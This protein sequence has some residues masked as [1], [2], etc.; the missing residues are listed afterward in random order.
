[1]MDRLKMQYLDKQFLTEKIGF[2]DVRAHDLISSDNYNESKLLERYNSYNETDRIL[3]YKA[4][5]QLSIIG[6]GQKN[7]GAIRID[8][9]NVINLVDI[10]KKL[11]IKFN[12]NI[13]AKY[14]E[15]EFSVRRLFRFFRYQIQKFIVDNNRPS[16]LWL[17][18]SDK[19]IKFVHIC[20]PGAEHF[21]EKEE[22]LYLLN[23]YKNLDFTMKTKFVDRLKRVYIARGLFT[24][25][26]MEK[27]IPTV[28]GSAT[29]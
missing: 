24:P 23:T 25:L 20:F 16:Y 18:Y 4:A 12:E 28:F 19:D 7:Y 22:A 6:Y 15:D 29:I 26:E 1:V 5:I 10:F 2:V 17:K 27:I 9:N 14:E 11:K 8:D 13:N 21:V 3:L